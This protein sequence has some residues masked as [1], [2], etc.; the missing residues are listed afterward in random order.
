ML[1]SDFRAAARRERLSMPIVATVVF[2]V[3]VS[4]SL[5]G[6]LKVLVSVSFEIQARKTLRPND[7]SADAYRSGRLPISKQERRENAR[8]SPSLQ[9]CLLIVHI[10]VS[11]G[12]NQSASFEIR[13]RKTLRPNGDSAMLTRGGSLPISKQERRENARRSPSLR[14]SVLHVRTVV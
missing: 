7:D 10:I 9:E 1:P 4:S 14:G 12:S 13:A 8:R 11:S 2:S 5:V 3:S 6:Q